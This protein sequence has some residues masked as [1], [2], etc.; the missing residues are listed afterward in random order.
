[1]RGHSEKRLGEC[2]EVG[3]ISERGVFEIMECFV[4]DSLDEQVNV[5]DSLPGRY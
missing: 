5:I 1:M 3:Y 4:L 2:S